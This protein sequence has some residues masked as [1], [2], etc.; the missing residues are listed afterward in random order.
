[1]LMRILLLP[2]LLLRMLLCMRILLLLLLPLLLVLYFIFIRMFEH[3]S[4]ASANAAAARRR[5]QVG[6][7]GALYWMDAVVTFHQA[8]LPAYLDHPVVGR[9]LCWMLWRAAEWRGIR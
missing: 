3:C 4:H 8:H 1:M 7:E 2:L 5:R 6:N 9:R